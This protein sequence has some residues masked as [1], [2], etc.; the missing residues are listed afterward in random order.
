[1]HCRGNHPSCIRC[2]S[3][4]PT[5]MQYG[6]KPMTNLAKNTFAQ[7]SRLSALWD[8]LLSD[9]VP[10]RP[11]TRRGGREPVSPPL[12]RDLEH[13]EHPSAPGTY[14][15]DDFPD[16]ARPV[17]RMW[18]NSLGTIW[19]T[20]LEPVP[21]SMDPADSEPEV[22]SEMSIE[23]AHEEALALISPFRWNPKPAWTNTPIPQRPPLSNAPAPHHAVTRPKIPL[24][25]LHKRPFYKRFF[26]YLQHWLNKPK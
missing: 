13:T 17:T 1:M 8:D 16:A 2:A 3:P 5:R 12:P 22:V 11:V 26:F 6:N 18:K 9:P 14:G 19:Q 24:R 4:E 23:A 10:P 15:P 25:P 20:L 7:T 21:L